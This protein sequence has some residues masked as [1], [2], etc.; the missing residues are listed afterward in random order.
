M[1]TAE[2][3]FVKDVVKRL[4]KVGCHVQRFEDA[5]SR[6]IPDINY[7]YQATSMWLEAKVVHVP[8]RPTTPVHLEWTEGQRLWAS[9][10]RR[11]GG[12]AYGLIKISRREILILGHWS[13]DA[14]LEVLRAGALCRGT[15][16]E[17]LA[18]LLQ[19]H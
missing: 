4:K 19:E 17:V 7:E 16:A 8:K 10:R 14:P 5:Y 2:K 6:F 15:L 13:E 18:W 3:N 12:H 11:A 1:K 9:D